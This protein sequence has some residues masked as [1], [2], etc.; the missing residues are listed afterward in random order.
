MS[1]MWISILITHIYL[2]V[3]L[4]L[5]YYNNDL[6]ILLFIGFPAI[7]L[8]MVYSILKDKKAPDRTFD[9][10]FYMD[11]DIKVNRGVRD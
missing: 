6:A 8:F 9:E 11:A 3:Y 7:M 10:Y 5:I 4:T 2:F 1:R